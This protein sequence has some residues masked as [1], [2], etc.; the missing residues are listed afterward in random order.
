MNADERRCAR[1]VETFRAG[2][3]RR[4][5]CGLLKSNGTATARDFRRAAGKGT[6]AALAEPKVFAQ[7]QACKLGRSLATD[8]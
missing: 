8:A 6:F 5:I 2:S 1:A 3:E 4:S 7:V